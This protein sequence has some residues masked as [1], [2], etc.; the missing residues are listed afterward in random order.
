MDLDAQPQVAVA[1]GDAMDALLA[2]LESGASDRIQSAE[3]L[4]PAAYRS[5]AF[6]D[7]EVAEI[8]RKDWLCVG[9]VSQVATVG[10]YF[11]IELFGEPMVVVRSKE[12]VRVLST[13]CRHRWVPVASG[14][15][16]TST[17]VCPFHKWTYR[18]DGT[19]IGA[20]LMEGVEFDKSDCRLPEFRS[21]VVD[22]LGLI[23]VTFSPDIEPASKRLSGLIE[24]VQQEGWKIKD[25]VVVGTVNM[26]NTYN[27]KI[28]VETYM[29]CYHHIGGHQDTLERLMPAAGSWCEDNKGTW[30]ICHA[31]LTADIESLSE[32]DKI[33]AASLAPTAA[34]GDAVG[35][36]VVIFPSTLLTFMD[37]GCDI[38]ILSPLS[39]LKTDSIVLTTRSAE[40]AARE[41]FDEWMKEYMV[42]WDIVNGEDNDLN[43]RQQVGVM[44]AGAAPG[45]LSTLEG[46]V[47]HLAEYVRS[48]MA[49]DAGSANG[50]PR[51]LS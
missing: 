6:F 49:P 31:S 9:H 5:Q 7:L 47:W 36:L 8:F 11:T 29:E 18:L 3:T 43:E 25:E 45:R 32:E 48:R 46:G 17:F 20:P 23:F 37:G 50:A 33:A 51:L 41:D 19:L 22:E 38:R 34:P 42:V 44:S 21:E 2:S 28:Q 4:P 16:H 27:W 14:S 15:G 10:D 35:H 40:F 24:R 39:P 1:Q 12:G 13:V 26:K 30:S